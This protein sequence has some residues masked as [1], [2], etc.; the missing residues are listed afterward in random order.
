ML[1]PSLFLKLDDSF[2]TAPVRLLVAFDSNSGI[3]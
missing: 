1:T 2:S 3:I